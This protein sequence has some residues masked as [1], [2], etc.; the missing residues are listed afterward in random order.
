MKIL[1][2][3]FNILL[4]MLRWI[5]LSLVLGM[6]VLVVF[7]VFYRYV[8]NDPIV[9]SDEIIMLMLLS[10]TYL[11]AALAASQRGHISVELLES[12]VKKQG[13]TALKKLRLIQDLVIVA[14]LG[15]ISLYAFKIA[16]FSQ[17]QQTD[18]MLLSYFWVYFILCL[19]MI[20]MIL[21]IFKRIYE[22]W[23]PGETNHY[24]KE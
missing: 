17:D 22:D 15:V 6:A 1:E 18:V 14:V 4:W 3:L 5:C 23:Y 24:I 11:G 20:F 7:N 2:R 16:R 8:L 12:L 9:W 13:E 19:G 21:M 10:L